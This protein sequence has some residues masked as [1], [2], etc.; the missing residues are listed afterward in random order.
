MTKQPC[1]SIN[2][3][4]VTTDIYADKSDIEAKIREAD[5]ICCCPNNVLAGC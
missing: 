1:S 4:H 5:A 3:K 2:G